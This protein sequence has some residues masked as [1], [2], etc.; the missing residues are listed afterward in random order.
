M[1]NF[2]LMVALVGFTVGLALSPLI[3]VAGVLLIEK[4]EQWKCARRTQ[5][6]SDNSTNS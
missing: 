6:R 5:N 2:Q 3:T 4:L 1:S